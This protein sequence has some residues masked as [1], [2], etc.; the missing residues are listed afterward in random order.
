MFNL[1]TWTKSINKLYDMK[2]FKIEEFTCDG[3]ICYDKMS[4]KLLKMLDQAREKANT[5]FKIT[6][7]W[8]SQEK[9]N[10]LKNSSKNSSHLKGM[11]VDIACNSGLERLKIFS[12]LVKAGFTRVGISDKGGFIHADCDDSKIDSLWIY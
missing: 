5:P 11:A 6:S 8:R 3:A 4:P 9:N 2:Y 1:G 7:S 10:S 12:G